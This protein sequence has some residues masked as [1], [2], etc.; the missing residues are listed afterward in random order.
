MKVLYLLFLS[1]IIMEGLPFG[2]S[3]HPVKEVVAWLHMK[4]CSSFRW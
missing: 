1:C 4:A 3:V 2:G